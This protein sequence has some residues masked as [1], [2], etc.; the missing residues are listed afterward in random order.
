MGEKIK[1]F[2]EK[3]KTV[4]DYVIKNRQLK[5]LALSMLL[6][7]LLSV[8]IIANVA[9]MPAFASDREL[10]CGMTAHTHSKGCYDTVDCTDAERIGCVVNIHH[11][12]AECRNSDGKLIC[13][14]ADYVIHKHNKYCY[15]S[16]NK[17]ICSLAGHC[18]EEHTHSS[19]CYDSNKKLTCTLPEVKAHTHTNSCYKTVTT[20]SESVLTCTLPTEPHVHGDSCYAASSNASST[21]ITLICTLSETAHTHGE[22]CYTVNENTGT[23]VSVLVC[24]QLETEVHNHIAS[25]VSEAKPKQKTVLSCGMTEHSHT[26]ECYAGKAV[27]GTDVSS[28]DSA[29]GKVYPSDVLSGSDAFADSEMMQLFN[30][31][32]LGDANEVLGESDPEVTVGSTLE[33]TIPSGKTVY[34]ILTPEFTHY[35]KLAFTYSSGYDYI[36]IYDENNTQL[37]YTT[38]NNTSTSLN[39]EGGKTYSLKIKN[40]YSSPRTLKITPTVADSNH[41]FSDGICTCG[42]KED[43]LNGSCGENAT[44]SFK[45]GVLTIS[46]SGAMT[47]FTSS[48][49]APWYNIRHSINQIVI[50]EDITSIG[51]YAFQNC[52]AINS[53]DIPDAVTSIGTYAFHG[54]TNLDNIVIPE[55]VTAI[56]PSTFQSCSSLTNIDIPDAVTSIGAYAFYGCTNLNNVVIPEGVTAIN[57]STFQNCSS[58]T[59]IDIPESVT[60]IGTYALSGCKNL[61]E[62]KLPDNLRSIGSDAFSFCTSLESIDIPESVTVIGS[63]AFDGCTKLNNVIIPAGV[64][65]ISGYAFRNCTSLSNIDIPDTVT[66]IGTYAFYRC[67][68]LSDI[69]IPDAVTSIGSYAFSGCA[70]LSDIDI[71]DTVTSIGSSAFSGC[72]NLDNVVI[73]DGVTAIKSGTFSGCTSLT[74]IDIPEGITIID[75]SAFQGCT[76]LESIDIP[77]SVKTINSSAFYNCTK[78]DDVVIPDGVSTVSN[79]A[80]YNCTSLSNIDLPDSIT[81]IGSSAFY[82]CSSLESIDIPEG[83]TYI[84]NNAF[85]NCS[86]LESIDIPEGVT[87]IGSS[88]FYNCSKLESIEL[89]DSTTTIYDKA[90]YNT[91]INDL[92]LHE[93]L[94]SAGSLIIRGDDTTKVYIDSAKLT[95]ISKT[96]VS[97][98]KLLD[99][100]TFGDKVNNITTSLVEF[101]EYLPN[102]TDLNFVGEN[103]LTIDKDMTIK[104]LGKTFEAGDYFVDAN[105]VLYKLDKENGTAELCYV[106]DELTEC[107]IID[108]TAADENGISYTVTSVKSGALKSA[109]ALTSIDF[110]APEN[111]VLLPDGAL[112]NCPSLEKVNGAE[113]VENAFKTFT[114]PAAIKGEQLF[115]NTG[116]EEEVRIIDGEVSIFGKDSDLIPLVKVITQKN[117][118][119]NNEEF[120]D[121]YT[122]YTGEYAK[123]TV[124]I[125]NANA[126]DYEVIR[127][128]FAF[129]NDNGQLSWP[130]GSQKFESEQGVEYDIKTVRSDI[131][132]VYYIECP[133]LVEGDTISAHINTLIP[134]PTSEGGKMRVWPAVLTAS[135]LE[136]IGNGVVTPSE[137][138]EVE[139]VT[140]PDDFSLRKTMSSNAT[141]ASKND[142]VYVANLTYYVYLNRTGNTLQGMGKDHITS[143]DYTDTLTLSEGLEWDEEVINAIRNGNIRA[144]INA[145]SSQSYIYLLVDGVQ[146]PFC[147]VYNNNYSTAPITKLSLALTEDNK[148]QIKWS[149][150]NNSVEKNELNATSYNLYFYR[151]TTSTYSI[152]GTSYTATYI[153]CIDPQPEKKY[154]IENDVN[155]LQHFSYS[156]DQYDE[157][158]IDKEFT[159]GEAYIDFYKTLDGKNTYWGGYVTYYLRAANKSLYSFDGLSYVNDPLSDK[160]YIKPDNIQKMF[161][162]FL[163]DT[164]Y[165]KEMSIKITTATLCSDTA[166]A[167][168]PGAE[169]TAADGTKHILTQANSGVGTLYHGCEA[170]DPA[171]Y[172]TDA[173]LI[174]TCKADGTQTLTY[175]DKVIDAGNVLS[176]LESVGFV[177]TAD[178][179]YEPIWVYADDYVMKPGTNHYFY[180]YSTFK[181]TFMLL[182]DDHPNYRTE[183]SHTLPSNYASLWYEESSGKL[184]EKNASY[185]Y[186][187]QFKRDFYINKSAVING[188]P[189][190]SSVFDG[191]IIAYTINANHYGGDTY[192]ILPLTDH[193]QGAQV[194]IVP[195]DGNEHLASDY[196]LTV[197]EIDGE[198]VYAINKVGTYNDVVIGGMIADSI[199]VTALDGG[200]YDTLIHWYLTEK[201]SSYTK[202]ITYKALVDTQTTDVDGLTYSLNNETWLNDHQSHRLWATL[203]YP[204]GLGGTGVYFDKYIVTE[205]GST[206][207]TDVLATYE[208][209][210]EGKPTLY[211]LT[212]ASI[213]DTVTLGGDDIFDSL[214]QTFHDALI[215]SK[216]NVS[217]RYEDAAGS[218]HY[219]NGVEGA[220]APWYI[221][222]VPPAW[223]GIGEHEDQQYIRWDSDMQLTIE[224]K[225]YIYVTLQLPDGDQWLDNAIKYRETR[226]EN[227]FYVLEEKMTVYHDLAEAAEAYLQKGV[228]DTGVN[229]WS[230]S[231][232]YQRSSPRRTT[233][234]SRLYFHNSTEITKQ[235]VTYYITLYNSGETRL[236]LNTIHD[237]LPDGVIPFTLRNTT[238]LTNVSLGTSYFT[239]WRSGSVNITDKDGNKLSPIWMTNFNT[240]PYYHADTNVITF[241]L[242]GGNLKYDN[243]FDKYYLAPNE[244]VKLIVPCY[245]QNR[246]FTGDYITNTVAMPYFDYLA[247]GVN[248]SSDNVELNNNSN[249]IPGAAL[250]DG[251]CEII[252][253]AQANHLGME[254][255]NSGTQ[256]LASDVTLRRGQIV[257]GITKWVESLTTPGGSTVS[258]AETAGTDD[259]INWAIKLTDSGN[260]DISVWRFT[261][262]MNPDYGFT[263]D[264][265]MS[266]K[267]LYT[268]RSLRLFTIVRDKENLDRVTIRYVKYPSGS[269]T[270]V[271]LTRN[272]ES[273]LLEDVSMYNG[274][275][276]IS[277]A[278]RYITSDISVRMYVDDKGNEVLSFDIL[279]PDITIPA[280]GNVTVKLSTKIFGTWANKVYYN[281]AYLAPLTQSYDETRV[282]QG[283][284]TI[285]G[286]G[287]DPSVR[288]SAQITAAYGY[289][290][291]SEKR[292]REIGNETNNASSRDTT[293]WIFL[294]EHSDTFRYT[295]LVSNITGK[296][297]SKFIMIDNL[298]EVGD[299]VTFAETEDRFSE[300]KVELLDDPNF[301]VF[302][303]LKGNKTVLTSDQYT[304]MF[305]DRTEFAEKDWNGTSDAGW[306]STPRKSTR[307]FRLEIYDDT[308]LVIPDLAVINVEYDGR[309]IMAA[310]YNNDNV[311]TDPEEGSIAW[312]SFG[313]H[314]SVLGE[315]ISLEAAPDKVGIC[316]QYVPLIRKTLVRPDG[317]EFTA[318]QDE[319]F[320]FIIYSGSQLSLKGKTEKEIAT[321]LKN[322]RRN[323]T[324][325]DL[326]VNKGESTS[327]ILRL[328]DLMTMT[329]DTA[330]NTWVE[331]NTEWRFK[332]G[333]NF[334]VFELD[335]TADMYD[336]RS[337][338]ASLTG[339]YT[340]AYNGQ[341]LTDIIAVNERKTWT[342]RINKTDAA[343]GK[344][345]ADAT[346]GIYSPNKNEQISDDDFDEL[347]LNRTPDKT[348][349]HNGEKWYLSQV[350]TTSAGGAAIF[351]GLVEDN[352]IVRELQSPGGY[353][354]AKDIYEF[355]LSD[356]DSTLSIAQDVVN[357]ADYELPK[358]GTSDAA[359]MI[360][361]GNL[362]MLSAAALFIFGKHLPQLKML[363]LQVK[364]NEKK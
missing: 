185:T 197:Q 216:D 265:K 170:P 318:E 78:L 181:D 291:S 259:T 227:S 301:E 205:K 37:T 157:A 276:Y 249:G 105:G 93:S 289:V 55:G 6:V 139:W 232:S 209:F 347:T 68:S 158:G 350:I 317:S 27:S 66:S 98:Y 130:F 312:N 128:Y 143:V 193:M 64:T 35:Y 165:L 77:D 113:T 299:H 2:I 245:V 8:N 208:P 163:E 123:V 352:Y 60:S 305:S 364:Q 103:F 135:Q 308:G 34:F 234:D 101:V 228:W 7:I 12:V 106:P 272:G 320:R 26:E 4:F 9:A 238:R 134:S 15:D 240:N 269:T 267:D 264:V 345:L 360:A 327:E 97:N 23:S 58:L 160:L 90:F 95:S 343:E 184:V 261:D 100:V 226:L 242:S 283:N 363:W 288:N 322:N 62:V 159:A 183:S 319:T 83:V 296:P 81:T 206:P 112:S 133:K 145:N 94:T 156:E 286:V 46:G 84:S 229:D 314:Y 70:S 306:Y 340:S 115:Y 351:E 335:N 124:G 338:A 79:N 202:N 76:S 284:H 248:V 348:V 333:E 337:I 280:D 29:G 180:I 298:P 210:M 189:D 256:W 122:Y 310:D 149:V 42:L 36:Y 99:N 196:G 164:A 176:A 137:C 266:Y 342:V 32:L 263:G 252:D 250:N 241:D 11:H 231:A 190:A 325:V 44:W 24:T 255:G 96:V 138:N 194:A 355:S 91:K 45:G 155:A 131:S 199:V 329:Y 53:I 108:K 88:A 220:D 28:S 315:R 141:L 211:R 73:P 362:M 102:L 344:A 285:F 339:S 207:N 72:T 219:V 144:T 336:V 167:H 221:D 54:C 132:N 21:D 282:S 39:L 200:G 117:N 270:P 175:G 230:T 213:N 168:T 129:D 13:G 89:P 302:T 14:M 51:A 278:Y 192:K 148:V 61:T 346:F 142:E 87:S 47:N 253:T 359:I 321:L 153:N 212:L 214:P 22:T 147:C 161:D 152:G 120:A 49:S 18:Y 74:N 71:P 274:S 313:Y 85:Y 136:K 169:I 118:G 201:N 273:V 307:S 260:E 171:E 262:V 80:F 195:A 246:D 247:A 334:T 223:T 268:T 309:I 17:L 40:G 127:V 316:I 191:D 154:T 239:E 56:N 204:G 258:A 254:G 126:G 236:Y 114:N 257:P 224:G 251:T 16:E 311:T 111:I 222:S 109:E 275:V 349:T 173:T 357:V 166:E 75:S 218:K 290:T 244:G 328:E 358:T 52:I 225:L 203:P 324:V 10:T 104:G 304:L 179:R 297:L 82:N 20:A 293:N 41:V 235:V 69:D 186:G 48:A 330:T 233:V 30:T 150:A 119:K 25:C 300:F 271:T 38:S 121:T 19:D 353:R 151:G 107:T 215:W 92:Y 43:D 140:K 146:K 281:N 177:V 217:L 182:N 279:N 172:D 125:S 174:L 57:T 277:G 331:T 67:T 292:I 65:S 354:L 287:N 303:N 31:L 33:Y 326:T 243:Y 187:Y 361:L 59:N 1:L 356:T 116:L 86:S 3:T 110:A 188:D 332:N 295:N 294:D 198:N 5:T 162:E 63:Y 178:V 341:T 50:S 323:V 237:A